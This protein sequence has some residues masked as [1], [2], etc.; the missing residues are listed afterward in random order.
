MVTL[1]IDSVRDD[2]YE[3]KGF[4]KTTYGVSKVALTTLTQVLA[5]DPQYINRNIL[6][7]SCCPGWVR[8]GL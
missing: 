3:E 7:N 1:F 6:I 2:T 5:R 4:P 8:T